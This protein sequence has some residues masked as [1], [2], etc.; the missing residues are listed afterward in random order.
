[1]T[2][3]AISQ[4]TELETSQDEDILAVVD[5]DEADVNIRTKKQ[6][7][8]NLLKEVK[9]E[10]TNKSD[11]DTAYD[12]GNHADAGYLKEDS[13]LNFTESD[14]R[15]KVPYNS[16]FQLNDSDFE[17]EFEVKMT[18]RDDGG[19][20]V[21][22]SFFSKIDDDFGDVGIGMFY[23]ANSEKLV[24]DL[25]QD[26]GSEYESVEI[27][28][29]KEN[30][31]DDAWHTLKV[32]RVG[33]NYNIF[34][35]GVDLGGDTFEGFNFND[36]YDLIIGNDHFLTSDVHGGMRNFKITK[37]GSVVGEWKMN[38]GDGDTVADTYGNNGTL[39][40]D[41]PTDSPVWLTTS[42]DTKSD[43]SAVPGTVIHGA[44]AGTARP[45]GFANIIW[46]GS[47]EPTNA[48]NNDIWYNVE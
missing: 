18:E 26:G 41:Y 19:V 44:T 10:L 8:E 1:M 7:K 20:N 9:E 46:I 29:P 23:F 14:H 12:W 6:T 2:N 27:E 21:S 17:I 39:L 42:I 11:W 32:V 5:V 25:V 36:E 48:E 33:N 43:K 22:Y 4:L 38:D 35:D 31:L 3:K 28:Y 16:A 34:V 15:I 13:Y 24:V 30:L 37:A 45:T 47:V 40:P